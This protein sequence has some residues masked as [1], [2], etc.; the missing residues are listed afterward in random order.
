MGGPLKKAPSIDRLPVIGIDETVHD[1]SA[2]K[3]PLDEP[4]EQKPVVPGP[5]HIHCED[6]IIGAR[7]SIVYEDCLTVIEYRNCKLK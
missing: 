6:D 5:Q 2:Y 7:A 4:G 3:D 1:Q